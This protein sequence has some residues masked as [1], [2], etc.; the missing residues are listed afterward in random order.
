MPKGK[1]DRIH[2]THLSFEEAVR[3]A[4]EAEPPP[5]D[6]KT[7]TAAEEAEQEQKRQIREEQESLLRPENRCNNDRNTRPG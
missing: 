7:R 5:K 4:W 1:A 3:Q 6:G 2:L